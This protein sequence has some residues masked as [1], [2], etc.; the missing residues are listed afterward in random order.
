MP[1]QDF[2]TEPYFFNAGPLGYLEGLSV[3]SSS[4]SYRYFGGVPYALPPVGPFRFR[5]ARPL[6]SH[7]RYGSKANPGRYNKSTAVCP[8]PGFRGDPDETLWDEDCLQLNIYIPSGVP[9]SGGWP[10]YFYI[11]GEFVLNQ[12]AMQC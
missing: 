2:H 8:Q 7:Y 5:Q 1:K 12:L 10:V 6:P 3:K 11:H 9:P 4:K